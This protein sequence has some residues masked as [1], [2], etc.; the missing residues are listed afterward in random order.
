MLLETLGLILTSS[1]AKSVAKFVY[2]KVDEY[3]RDKLGN[4]PPDEVG[5]LKKEVE[6]LRDKLESKD[7]DDI[8]STEVEELKRKIKQIE[9]GQSLLPANVISG[10][11]F[12]KWSLQETLDTE[13]QALLIMRQLEV[14]LDKAG[15]L[16]IKDRKRFQIQ[17]ICASLD[18]NIR[19][20]KD[21]RLMVRRNDLRSD[22]EEEEKRELLLRQIIFQAR[23]LLR[24]Y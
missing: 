4:K 3:V 6:D 10:E 8:T 2:E 19:K 18:F 7:R 9:Q 14:L 21:V 15:E 20:L 5:K 12:Q 24:G 1:T 16:G 11:V 22:K 23:D 13:D 17:D